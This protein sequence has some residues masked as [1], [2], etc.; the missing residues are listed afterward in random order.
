MFFLIRVLTFW[1]SFVQEFIKEKLFPDDLKIQLPELKIELMCQMQDCY[2]LF[3]CPGQD[4]F[5]ICLMLYIVFIFFRRISVFSWQR[6][7]NDLSKRK[8]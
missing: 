5:H 3:L 6:F 4:T 2:L 1:K 7:L 8:I